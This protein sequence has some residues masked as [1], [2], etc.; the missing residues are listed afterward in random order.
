MLWSIP[1]G[2]YLD[3]VVIYI[4]MRCNRYIHEN[5]ELFDLVTTYQVH[6]HSKS[7]RKYRNEKC[8]YYFGKCFTEM[9]IVSLSLPN[10]LPDR[11]KNNNAF[12]QW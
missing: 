1:S 2:V 3:G 11:V 4:Y 10:H 8:Q 12:Y 7:C 5:P 9:T 6:C